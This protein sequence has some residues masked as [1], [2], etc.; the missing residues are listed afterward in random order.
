MARKSEGWSISKDKRSGIYTVRF[1]F[2]GRQRHRSTRS[3]DF[4]GAQIEAARIYAEVISGRQRPE[5]ARCIAPLDELFALWLASVEPELAKETWDTYRGYCANHW[6]PFFSTVESITTASGDDYTRARLRKVKRSTVA[7]E[8]SGLRNFLRW[9]NTQGFLPD[10]PTIR[11]PP[12]RA[13]GTTFE[14]GKR[15]KVRV[16][17]NTTQAE[18]IIA[19]LPEHTPHAGYPIKALFT[20]IW[21]TSL[22]IG[23]MW[24]LEVPKH[25]KPGDAVLRITAEIDKSRYARDLPLSDRAAEV[26][27][28]VAP[29]SG[30][31]FR[32]FEYRRELY[33]AAKLVLNTDYEAKHLSAHDFRHAA[34]THMAAVGSDLTAI[35]HVAG[36]KNATTTAL[37]VHNSEAAARRAVDRRSAILDTQLDTDLGAQGGGHPSVPPNLPQSLVGHPGLEPGANGLR[38][39]C[40]TN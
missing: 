6:L 31:I 1:S 37:Y 3:R 28:A 12:K 26:L 25:F 23:T 38:I 27:D 22:R 11:N 40:S 39:H 20:V 8:L 36:H 18:A 29:T 32:R 30:I 35:G 4:A 5:Q 33:K 10:T 16:L 14:Q 7:K 21:E 13:T 9:A 17:L 15:E 24:R 34:V 19:R 2:Q